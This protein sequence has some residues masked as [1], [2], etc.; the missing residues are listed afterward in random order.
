ME[1]NEVVDAVSAKQLLEDLSLL[2]LNF[3]FSFEAMHSPAAALD[4]ICHRSQ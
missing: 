1:T 2:L 4:E 3:A